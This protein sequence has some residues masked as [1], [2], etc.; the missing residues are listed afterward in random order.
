MFWMKYFFHN[1]NYKYENSVTIL[2]YVRKTE[3]IWYHL[4]NGNYIQVDHEI[5]HLPIYWLC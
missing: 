1:K 2:G 5:A 4:D 3:I